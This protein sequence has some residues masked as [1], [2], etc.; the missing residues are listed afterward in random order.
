MTRNSTLGKR[1]AGHCR[2]YGTPVIRIG[3]HKWR[4]DKG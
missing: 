1:D 3:H 2:H 4:R